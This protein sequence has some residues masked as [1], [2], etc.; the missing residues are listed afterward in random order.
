[1]YRL[2][3]FFLEMLFTLKVILL[4]GHLHG[5]YRGVRTW[6]IAGSFKHSRFPLGLD[7]FSVLT[8]LLQLLSNHAVWLSVEHDGE[9]MMG[10]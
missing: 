1:M 3:C 6:K 8:K 5:Q 4:P 7:L 10:Y 2:G 9:Q